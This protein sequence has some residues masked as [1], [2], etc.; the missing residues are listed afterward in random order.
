M[1]GLHCPEGFFINPFLA[2][3]LNE[4]KS[5]R[6]LRIS[7]NR[8]DAR[9][10]EQI[11]KIPAMEEVD[12]SG[13]NIG[14][15]STAILSVFDGIQTLNVSDTLLTSQGVETLQAKL[16]KVKILWND[17]ENDRSVAARLSKKNATIEIKIGPIKQK[18]LPGTSLPSVPFRIVSIKA[19]E[20]EGL[21]TEDFKGVEQLDALEAIDLLHTRLDDSVL[22]KL[23]GLTKLK[24][25]G[26]GDTAMKG[27]VLAQ[28]ETMPELA[29]IVFGGSLQNESLAYFSKFPHLNSIFLSWTDIDD[30]G[31]K[32]LPEL[33]RVNRLS[34]ERTKVRGPGLAELRRLTNL[35][36]LDLSHTL[37]TD[38]GLMKLPELAKLAD[39]KLRKLP[40]TDKSI[41][42]LAELKS[43]RKLDLSSTSF[44][45][46]GIDTLR[47]KLPNCAITWTDHA[48]Q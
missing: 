3:R 23:K 37:V 32:L 10:F 30:A 19:E 48:Q 42:R 20:K 33:S 45:A 22:E 29:M 43:L 9:L 18:L 17:R 46:T 34:L 14:D 5:L 24:I 31:L 11:S 28:F 47:I 6:R 15:S 40:L 8:P 2:A 44:T 25:L 1:E 26:C 13:S 36:Q 41:S 7:I 38:E 39:L 16:H 27:E 12:L 4:I 35:Q 21:T